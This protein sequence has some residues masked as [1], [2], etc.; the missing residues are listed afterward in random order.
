VDWHRDPWRKRRERQVRP[1]RRR[2]RNRD[3]IREPEFKRQVTRCRCELEI[4]DLTGVEIH[5]DPFDRLIVAT[6]L[7]LD[8]PVVTSDRIFADY[9]VDIWL[10]D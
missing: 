6:A 10:V 5:R 1:R 7:A 8:L 2:R 4:V 3:E 9:G